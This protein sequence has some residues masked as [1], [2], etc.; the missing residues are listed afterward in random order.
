MAGIFTHLYRVMNEILR[1]LGSSLAGANSTMISPYGAKY[2]LCI[3]HAVH[4]A[5][6]VAVVSRD[7][8]L[9]NPKCLVVQLDYNLRVEVEIISHPGK[10]YL[11]K[12]GQAIGP[13]AAVKFRQIHP[14]RPVLE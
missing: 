13:V 6:F 8:H 11:P 3:F 5:D 2:I 7:W 14:Q 4:V 9:V 1:K 12:G 10:V